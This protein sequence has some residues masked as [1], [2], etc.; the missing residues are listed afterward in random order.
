MTPRRGSVGAA[1]QGAI[2]GEF[3]R[4]GNVAERN[5]PV[6]FTRHRLFSLTPQRVDSLTTTV[7]VEAALQNATELSF[8]PYFER[9]M[10]LERSDKRLIFSNQ[11]EIC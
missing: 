5:E 10:A 3:D 1:G 11:E 7:Q 4:L 9:A 6:S 8:H 2:A